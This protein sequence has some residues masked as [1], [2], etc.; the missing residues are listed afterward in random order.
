MKTWCIILTCP[1]EDTSSLL[2]HTLLD[3][4]MKIRKKS[5]WEGIIFPAGYLFFQKWSFKMPKKKKLLE[6]HHRWNQYVASWEQPSC[7]S[8]MWN[9]RRNTSAGYWTIAYCVIHAKYARMMHTYLQ[10][11]SRP[12]NQHLCFTVPKKNPHFSFHW[13]FCWLATDFI[14]VALML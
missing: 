13:Q 5:W 12:S 9:T 2:V 3:T 10:H 6:I 1:R 8:F 14:K 11:T 7:S 4:Q